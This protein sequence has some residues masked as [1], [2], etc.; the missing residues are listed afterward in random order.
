[1]RYELTVTEQ[2]RKAGSKSMKKRIAMIAILLLVISITGCANTNQDPKSDQTITVA[3]TIAEPTPSQEVD[4]GVSYEFSVEALTKLAES[5]TADVLKGEFEGVNSYLTEDI[6]ATYTVEVL[7]KAYDDTVK[8][9]G[10]FVE[11]DSVINQEKEN[12]I[13]IQVILRF[14]NN[15]L[16]LTYGFNHN[17]KLSTFYIS[18]KNLGEDEVASD[19]YSE[20]EI[21][22]GDINEPLDGLLTLP[23]GVSNPP[24]VILVHGSGQNDMDETIGAVSN[25]PFRDLAHG[26]AK[27]GI[28][29]IRYN[30]RYYQYTDNIP[31]NMTVYDEVLNDVASAILLAKE[32]GDVD[33][34]RI[35][36]VGHSLGGMLC[37][38]IAL[39]H[40][41]VVGIISLAGS[42]RNLEDIIYDQAVYL[43][44]IDET[45]SEDEKTLYLESIQADVERVKNLTDQEL[46][47]P[48]LGCTGYYWKSLLEIDTKTIVTELK[49]P[50]L[51]LQG[52][53]DFQVF[54]NIDFAMWK[55]LLEGNENVSFIQYEGLNHLFMPT[56]GATDIEDYNTK[57]K[58]SNQVIQDIS[59]WIHKQ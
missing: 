4:T 56:T 2:P 17:I 32:R 57:A 52:S 20:Y 23:S 7:K 48:I 35:Y 54:P 5:M 51:F 27:N 25:K 18:Y 24:V 40:E 37:P 49:I 53:A 39:D 22:V 47:E 36:V 15:G 28:A 31:E 13:M 21:T 10:K 58:V 38:K 29:S 9:L 46:S 50:M 8:P 1:M 59:D 3:P 45:S 33:A 43:A 16:V 42:P 41:E 19:L 26:L 34:S 30:K 11:V 6:Q 55:E 44:Q 12:L 14:E